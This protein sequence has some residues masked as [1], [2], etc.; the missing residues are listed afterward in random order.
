VYISADEFA[1]KKG[2]PCAATLGTFD[3]FHLG[4][5][6]I[7]AALQRRARDLG[8]SPVAITFDPHPRMI[9]TPDNP[10][11]LLTTREEKIEIL[12]ERFNGSLVFLKFDDTLRN[13][14]AEEFARD[15]LI[16][17]F[18]IKAL[19]VGFNHSFGRDRS[20]TAEHLHSIGAREGFDVEVV[21]PVKYRDDAVSSSRIRRAINAGE[22][23]D[24]LAMLGHPY[25]I[26]GI[27]AKGLGE[28]KKMGWPTINLDWSERKLL[29]REGVY[30]CMA[31]VNGDLYK[32]M[33][34]IGVN[35]LNPEKSLSVEANLFDFD[36]DVYEKAV[37]LYPK[38][39]VRGIA[40][41]D[42][43]AELALQIERDKKKIIDLL[44]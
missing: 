15:I 28:G 34:F 36:R 18:A 5:K 38:H 44:T 23:S 24:A 3:G 42:S 37:T 27:V 31:S 16:E 8:L 2:G 40:R 19:V 20:G 10:P 7:F 35:M 43:A 17:R 26:H 12:S 29:P 21:G 33:M 9:V 14:S 1:S 39:Y 22:W 25:P 13:M 4:H 32:G 11:Q 6:S 30:S 41:F